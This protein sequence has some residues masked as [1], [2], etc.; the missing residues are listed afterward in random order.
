[1]E[2]RQ[3]YR[4][5]GQRP[6]RMRRRQPV[7]ERD[8]QQW[9]IGSYQTVEWMDRQTTGGCTIASAIPPL[10]EA[11]ATVVEPDDPDLTREQERQLVHLLAQ[12][13]QTDWWLG[14][15]HTGSDDIVFP[16]ADEVRLYAGWPYVLV[17]AGP[18][19]ALSWRERLP[20]LIFPLD[21]SWC[22]STLWDDDW[23]CI[24]GT[25]TLLTALADDPLVRA[26]LVTLDQ[27]ATP[28]GHTAI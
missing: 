13:G 5:A 23:T 16:H 24:G 11:Y 6:A 15:L 8:G 19:Q 21:R 26:R 7:D 25:S 20:D 4:M 10:Y 12:Q 3:R 27:D 2:R 1:V 18:A 22:L 28:P 14:Y 17:Q 9:R